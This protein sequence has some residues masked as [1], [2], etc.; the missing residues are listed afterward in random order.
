MDLIPRFIEGK[1]NPKS[2]EYPHESL[3]VAL[4]ETYGVMVY[5][6][7]ILHIANIMADYSLGEAD[8]LRRA[9]GKKKKKLLDQNK[10]RFISQS[11]KKGYEPAVAQKVWEYI[12]AFANYGFN[13]A[14]A[15]SYAMIAYQ[16]AYLKAN[17]PVEYMTALM[18][19]ESASSSMNRDTKVAVAIENSKRMGIQVLPPDIN[20]SD[21]DFIIEL[22]ENS[23]EGKA[24]RFGFNA[25]K[26]LGSA[27][28][29]EIL[30]RKEVGEFTH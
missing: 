3:K 7:Q 5:Q 19:V 10:K 18:S 22:A 20:L 28:I 6:E 9:I 1:H 27:A 4:E 8:I 17:Y 24:I 30:K 29:D 21:D 23:L 16:T 13:K 2:I 12:E 26:H 11:V 15:A 14:H 25:I